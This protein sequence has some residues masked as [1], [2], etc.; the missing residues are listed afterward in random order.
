[1]VRYKIVHN[2]CTTELIKSGHWLE[3]LEPWWFDRQGLT[4]SK[5]AD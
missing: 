5:L 2:I 1:M 4:P 3:T